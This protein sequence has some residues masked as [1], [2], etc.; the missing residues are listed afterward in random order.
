METEQI[1]RDIARMTVTVG[2]T[3][4]DEDGISRLESD[5][6]APGILPVVPQV[7]HVILV[8]LARKKF[9]KY[10]VSLVQHGRLWQKGDGGVTELEYIISVTAHEV[11][12]YEL[13]E[14]TKRF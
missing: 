6:Y 13:R 5:R 2:I 1:T 11:D 4:M 7:G 12:D 9:K 8:P 14:R 10:L 3:F